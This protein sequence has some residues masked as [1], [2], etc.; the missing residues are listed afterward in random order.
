MIYLL[1]PEWRRQVARR[2]RRVQ[3]IAP[4]DGTERALWTAISIAAGVGE[5]ITYRGVLYFVVTALIGSPAVSV[6][7]CSALFGISHL[8]HGGR[9]AAIALAFAV[10]FHLLVIGTGSLYPAMAVH[11]LYDLIAGLSYGRLAA[12][13][14][15][16]LE[17]EPSVSLTDSSARIP[18]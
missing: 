6:V 8:V 10:G 11:A 16:P 14:G 9:G 12:E 5:E 15:Y 2:D 1:R 18:S 17:G 3:L 4:R 7:V 13:A